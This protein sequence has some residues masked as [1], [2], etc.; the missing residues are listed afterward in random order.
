MAFGRLAL[1]RA[2]RNQPFLQSGNRI[3]ASGL[4]RHVEIREVLDR[5][6]KSRGGES[7]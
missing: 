2:E 1:G 6:P 7:P 3:A 5:S 4:A